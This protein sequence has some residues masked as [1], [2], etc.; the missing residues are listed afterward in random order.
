[1]SGVIEWSPQPIVKLKSPFAVDEKQNL[2]ITQRSI[3]RANY[4]L[5]PER[6]EGHKIH[7]RVLSSAKKIPN[8]INVP[9]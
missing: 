2:S 4:K 7:K 8:L 6:G 1:M 9:P 5:S 3:A